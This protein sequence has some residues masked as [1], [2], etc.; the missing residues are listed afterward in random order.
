MGTNPDNTGTMDDRT[1]AKELGIPENAAVM[2]CAEVRRPVIR[3]STRLRAVS[4]GDRVL[5]NGAVILRKKSHQ[6]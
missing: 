6:V 4:S 1:G 3:G 2:F 5:F